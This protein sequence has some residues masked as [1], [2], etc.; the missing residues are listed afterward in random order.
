MTLTITPGREDA[1]KSAGA[2]CFFAK[3]REAGLEGR[4]LASMSDAE[5][6][7]VGEA[8]AGAL[9]VEARMRETVSV[10]LPGVPMIEDA[11]AAR[12]LIEPIGDVTAADMSAALTASGV[13]MI[14]S[15]AE[16]ITSGRG[17]WMRLSQ[18]GRET[19]SKL[20][21]RADQARAAQ[22][23]LTTPDADPYTADSLLELPGVPS[24]VAKPRLT[25][26]E[27]LAECRREEAVEA[28]W[29]REAGTTALPTYG[30]GPDGKGGTLPE[31]AYDDGTS[32]AL[33]TELYS[34]IAN[35]NGANGESLEQHKV[36][37]LART[38]LGGK[39]LSTV[40][41]GVLKE[42]ES[43]YADELKALRE[44]DDGSQDWMT[45]PSP[46]SARVVATPGRSQTAD[47]AAGR[48]AA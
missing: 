31:I 9:A 47:A 14:P 5:Q 22:R 45:V 40:Q 18:A 16:R 15:F 30:G 20:A 17:P 10:D 35:E 7:V 6:R 41:I 24:T 29:L 3:L 13:P 26:D 39:P 12:V 36:E 4:S 48:V 38:I 11:G 19:V 32:Y 28:E 25:G 43:T 21:A 46:G 44:S 1:I 8:T 33:V 27:L 34:L 37:D 23:V 42:L 2:A